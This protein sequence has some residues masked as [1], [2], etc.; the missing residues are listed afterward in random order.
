MVLDRV[1]IWDMKKD[2]ESLSSKDI[3]TLAKYHGFKDVPYQDLLWMIALSN[4]SLFKRAEMNGDSIKDYEQIRK[5]GS[6]TFGKVYQIRRKEDGSIL[7]WKVID[8]S[9]S[10]PG[11]KQQFVNET[12]ILQN[13]QHP[14]IS[15]Y[16]G[17]IV[18]RD[19]SKLYV[20]MEY[21]PGSDLEEFVSGNPLQPIESLELMKS[22]AETLQYIHQKNVVHR[23]IKPENILITSNKQPKYIDFGFSCITETQDPSSQPTST[24]EKIKHSAECESL[25][26]GTPYFMSPEVYTIGK[27]DPMASRHPLE[28]FRMYKAADVW[29]LGLMFYF[30]LYS[31]YPQSF[32]QAQSDYDFYRAVAGGVIDFPQLND[33]LLD[34]LAEITK[35]MLIRGSRRSTIDNVV[36]ELNNVPEEHFKE[37]S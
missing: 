31:K 27:S 29:A 34:R 19:N 11:E 2:L 30:I 13:L 22:L 18:D 17:R 37:E 6:G 7:A 10:T 14:G 24:W 28:L 20:L 15:S 25:R 32:E 5:L 23:D 26:A 3:A 33:K 21:V 12:N 8:Y 1:N 16:Y 36:E 9:D 35:G 4:E